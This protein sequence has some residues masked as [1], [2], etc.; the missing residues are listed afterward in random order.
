MGVLHKLRIP[1]LCIPE[2]MTAGKGK[3]KIFIMKNNSRVEIA[4]FIRIDEQYNNQGIKI[5]FYRNNSK[6]KLKVHRYLLADCLGNTSKVVRYHN[7]L[8][9]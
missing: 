9:F 6:N 4:R 1:L 5:N 3:V 7:N 2:Q 8:N